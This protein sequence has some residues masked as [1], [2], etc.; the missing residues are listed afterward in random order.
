MEHVAKKFTDYEAYA[1]GKVA[2]V[3]EAAVAEQ[4]DDK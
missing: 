4:Q 1:P 3:D 2:D